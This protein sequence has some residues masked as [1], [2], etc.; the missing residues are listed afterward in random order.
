MSKI[1]LVRKP[2]AGES[3]QVQHK[4]EPVDLDAE[5]YISVQ[6]ARTVEIV[7]GDQLARAKAFSLKT[8]SLAVIT[9]GA[10][11]VVS[12]LIL[13]FPLMSLVAL[14]WFTG[15]F[16]LVW[17]IAFALDLYLSPAGVDMYHARSYWDVVKREQRYRHSKEEDL[18][19]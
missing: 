5:S 17:L 8:T 3:Y 6:D 9:G 7:E 18:W 4:R 16:M 14:A 12:K 15:G 11:L 1:R 2:G 19:E 13:A 10:M